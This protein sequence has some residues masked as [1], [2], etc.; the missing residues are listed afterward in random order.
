MRKAN[1]RLFNIAFLWFAFV[2]LTLCLAMT[3]AFLT[4]T[5]S[6]SGSSKLGNLSVA[7]KVNGTAYTQGNSYSNAVFNT[8]TAMPGDNLT[9]PLSLV[10]TF[11]LAD[12]NGIYAR[13]KVTSTITPSN[14]A[15]LTINNNSNWTLNLSGHETGYYYYTGGTSAL[16]AIT[17]SGS[18]VAFST[19]IVVPASVTNQSTKI[20]LAVTAETTQVGYQESSLVWKNTNNLFINGDGSFGDN[21]NWTELTYSTDNSSPS[22]TAFSYS[23][24]GNINKHISTG[25]YVE[26]DIAKSYNLSVYAKDSTGVDKYYFGLVACDADKK[27][28]KP[29]NTTWIEGS[30]TKLARDV[31]NGD[32]VIY[33]EDVSGFVNHQYYYRM[34]FIIWDYKDSTGYQYPKE[35]YSQNVYFGSSSLFLFNYE[36]IDFANN[37]INLNYAWN[38]GTHTAGADI[39]QS[40][41]GSTYMYCLLSNKP[42]T[43]SWKQYSATISGYQINSIKDTQFRQGTKYVRLL[44]NRIVN[45]STDIITTSLTNISIKEV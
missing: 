19:G 16:K 31:K 38:G 14:A 8:D 45:N 22:G 32:T 37:C 3:F 28:I 4:H 44:I 24:A 42:M 29:R 33:L 11:S 12:G 17:T 26:V 40:N 41:D 34:G 7:V 15:T 9:G 35:T 10:P 39:S 30:T 1:R 18:E 13:I 6:V 25:N 36:D 27:T 20:Q 5:S 21:T 23:L 43:T 2:T